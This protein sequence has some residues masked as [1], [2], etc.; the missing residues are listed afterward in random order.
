MAVDPNGCC[1][2]LCKVLQ[3]LVNSKKLTAEK[4]DDILRQFTDLVTYAI[5]PKKAEFSAFDPFDEGHHVDIFLEKFIN[6]SGF[7][8][9]WKTVLLLFHGQAS[10]ERRFS[11]NHQKEVDNLYGWIIYWVTLENGNLK[12]LEFNCKLYV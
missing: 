4:C 6:C 9:P 7:D 1:A 10:N 11:V 5:I 3:T 12:T 2:K 8:D